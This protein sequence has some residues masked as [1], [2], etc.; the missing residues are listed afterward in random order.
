MAGLV[1]FW[2]SG[3]WRALA[4]GTARAFFFLSIFF[5]LGNARGARQRRDFGSLGLF[6]LGQE[7]ELIF[8]RERG[9]FGV[10]GGLSCVDRH[11][12]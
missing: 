5:L 9:F 2:F 4:K 8:A 6:E 3:R 10:G 7:K 1:S 12:K 11:L